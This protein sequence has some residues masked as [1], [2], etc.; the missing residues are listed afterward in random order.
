MKLYRSI[1]FVPGNRPDWIDKAPKYGP[2]ALILD[3]E[4][5][6]P[7]VEKVEARK[8][9]RAGIERSRE[10]GVPIVVRVN[11]I[12]TG[13]TGEDVEAIVTNGLVAVAIPK[14]ER[15]EEVLKVDAWIE[16]FER[17][18][19]MPIGGV[20]IVAL[21]ETA[22]GIM[23][24]YQLAT[25]CPRVGNIVG[26]VGARSGD[27]TKAIG[28]KWTRAG[29]ETLY[30]ASHMLLA[31]RAAGIEYP[32]GGG[33]LEVGDTELVRAQ[34]QRAREVGYRGALLIHPSAVPIANEVFA[35]SQEEIEWNKGVLRAMAEAE[36]AGRAAVTYDGMMIDYAHVRNA[37]DLLHQAEAFGLTVGEYPQV[38]AL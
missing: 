18:A 15:A 36:Q 38:K 7:N 3:L 9:V 33:S 4:D 12:N 19:G 26:G 5:A 23:N 10:R 37:L 21:P 11:G 34:L 2:D 1:L 6:V 13:L 27:V 20:E 16:L 24:I 14:L 28:Y 30:M 29:L 22:R 32:L 17:K 35:P 8:T 25:A 31:A